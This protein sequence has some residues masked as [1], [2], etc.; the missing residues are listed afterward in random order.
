EEELYGDAL[1]THLPLRLVKAGQLPGH[2]RRSRV[3]PRGALWAAVTV[4]DLE[5]QIINTHLGLFPAE[6]L[7]Q[8]EAL[9]GEEWLAHPSCRP[10]VV[11]CGDLNAAPSSMVCRRIGVQL[12]DAQLHGPPGRPK[13]TWFGRYPTM[14]IDHIFVDAG[15][16]VLGIDV[17]HNA[18]VQVA[19]D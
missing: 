12:R 6:R 7:A 5:L 1:L 3:E 13:N 10:P 16:E 2:P 8:I 4:G 18:L 15:I 9:L 14:R 17:P 11:L 19:S